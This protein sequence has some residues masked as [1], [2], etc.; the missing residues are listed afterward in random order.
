MISDR[1]NA[2]RARIAMVRMYGIKE[3]MRANDSNRK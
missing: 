1:L 3:H 2:G